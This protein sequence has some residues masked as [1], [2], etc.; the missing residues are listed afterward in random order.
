[1]DVNNLTGRG[2]LVTEEIE[3]LMKESKSLNVGEA[4]TGTEALACYTG[5]ATSST[6]PAEETVTG[7][8]IGKWEDV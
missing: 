5:M 6:L 7:T 8:D 4:S 3:G 2:T 1:M